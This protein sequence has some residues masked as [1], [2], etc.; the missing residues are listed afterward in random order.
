MARSGEFELI[1][2]YFA[3][4]SANGSFSL[5][6]DAALLEVPSGKELVVTQDA[7][8]AGV[9]FFADDSPAMIAKKAIRVNL[10][11]LASKGAKPETFSM[12]LGLHPDWNE[13][14]L[15]KFAEGLSE[16]CSDFSLTLCGG[17]TYSVACGPVVSITAF[18]LIDKECYA[19]R[20]GANPGDELFVSGPI[21]MGALGLLVRKGI[22]NWPDQSAAD[23][24]LSRYLVPEPPLALASVISEYASAAMDISDGFAGD[25]E[26]MATASG[27]GFDIP[28]ESIPL[29]EVLDSYPINAWEISVALTGGDDYQFVLTVPPAEVDDMLTSVSRL[30]I[31][32][33]HLA[34]ANE[35]PGNVR[36]LDRDGDQIPLKSKSWRHF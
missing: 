27:V 35:H 13:D 28:F 11:D 10:S 25:I 18:G 33:S 36:I 19:T 4:L 20:M 14:W 23:A 29:P 30:E 8:A 1:Q 7:I 16:D 9:H 21:G 2:R 5:K 17:D 15:A 6:D 34:T 32:L 22:F 3:P 31:Q 24:F 26:K 12:A